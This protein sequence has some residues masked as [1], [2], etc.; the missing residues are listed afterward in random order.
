MAQRDTAQDV[1]P[2]T[3]GHLPPGLTWTKALDVLVGTDDHQIFINALGMALAESGNECLYKPVIQQR[4]A[5]VHVAVPELY[6]GRLLEL[7]SRHCR[8]A[9]VIG[10]VTFIH[11][12]CLRLLRMVCHLQKP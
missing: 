8:V 9:G 5:L 12:P 2:D 6:A 10:I 1:Q 4:C 7:V 11:S 3:N